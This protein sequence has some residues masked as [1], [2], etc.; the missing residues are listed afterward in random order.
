MSRSGR[1]VTIVAFASVAF[2][3]AYPMQVNAWNQNAHY[4]LVRALADGTPTI[5]KSRTEIGDLGTGDVTLVNGHY[6]SN[7]AP[8]LA[9]VTLP[10]FVVVDA[11]G[12][13]TTGDPTKVI[14]VLHLWAIALP[15]A[16]ARRARPV[17]RRP[18]RA[19][20]RTR[21]GGDARL[22]H[23]GAAVRNDVLRARPR[24]RVHVRR[25]R[26][27]SSTS[28]VGRGGSGSSPSPAC[29]AGS[30]RRRSTRPVSPPS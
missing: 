22:R 3:F 12:M 4:A 5:D 18:A 13:R 19:G 23:A 28:V 14:W 6:Y 26:S 2:A 1:L 24:G 10:A 27:Y 29:W 16:P 9:F 7:K 20:L 30:P 8:G 17:R 25:V 11:L 21:G 15:G